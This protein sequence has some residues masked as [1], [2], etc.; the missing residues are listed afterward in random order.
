MLGAGDR[1]V[2]KIHGPCPCGLVEETDITEMLTL[3]R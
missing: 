3:M 1:I 2:K